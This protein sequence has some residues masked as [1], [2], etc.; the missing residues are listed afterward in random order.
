MATPLARMHACGQ[1]PPPFYSHAAAA[2]CAQIRTC[3][4]YVDMWCGP[5]SMACSSDRP[6][7]SSVSC[8]RGGHGVCSTWV[9]GTASCMHS[10]WQG[11]GWA[12]GATPLQS[13]CP[14]IERGRGRARE[15]QGTRRLGRVPTAGQACH[16]RSCPLG[17]RLHK[18]ALHM[19][20]Q[21]R[22]NQRPHPKPAL[23]PLPEAGP[24]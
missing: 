17:G 20:S 14:G 16:V 10:Q 23:R 6:H 11:A 18:K 12:L 19:S 13:S 22:P 9:N 7:A 1:T 24:T 5:A 8:Q 3:R 15:G 21:Q 4:S 2:H